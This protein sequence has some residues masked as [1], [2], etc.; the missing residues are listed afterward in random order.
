M[1]VT[2]TQIRDLLNRPRG[3]NEETIT[4]YVTI[5]TAQIN[6]IARSSALYTISTDN[7]ITDALKESAIKFS[8]AVDCL[9]VLIDTIPSYYPQ[10]EQ[11][12]N[13]QR[14]R[15]QLRRFQKQADE[16]IAVIKD[17]GLAAFHIKALKTKQ[18]STST[19]PTTETRT[20]G[21]TD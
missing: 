5:R 8:V 7:Q 3:L 10:N 6:K 11:G 19:G 1:A 21:L 2:N 16:M 17:K 4:E 9:V 15:D 14:F 12:A 13:D 20:L 18:I